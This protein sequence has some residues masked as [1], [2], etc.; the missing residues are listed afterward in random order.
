MVLFRSPIEMALFL[1][2]QNGEKEVFTV[3]VV[4]KRNRPICAKQALS[5]P[6]PL[7][8]L[9]SHTYPLM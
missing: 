2:F 4:G 5:C 1:L 3:E 8:S 7:E 6:P 9:C